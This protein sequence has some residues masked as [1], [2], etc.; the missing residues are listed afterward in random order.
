MWLEKSPLYARISHVL[1]PEQRLDIGVVVGFERELGYFSL[2]E[3]ADLRGPLGLPIE[4]DLAFKPTP[5]S[6]C[7]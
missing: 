2:D 4:R 5:A 1:H 3:L 7:L 6:Q